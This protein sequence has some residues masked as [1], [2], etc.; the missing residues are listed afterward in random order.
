MVWRDLGNGPQPS[1]PRTRAVI[2]LPQAFRPA[3]TRPSQHKHSFGTR[4]NLAF[5]LLQP[6]SYTSFCNRS[7][8]LFLEEHIQVISQFYKKKWGK[9]IRC[10]NYLR[11]EFKTNMLTISLRHTHKTTFLHVNNNKTLLG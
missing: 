5:E 3:S 9:T 6:T 2:L 11:S 1:G 7:F 4:C 10:T 8:F